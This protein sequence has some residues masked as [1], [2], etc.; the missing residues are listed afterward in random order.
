MKRI[1][2]PKQD[3]PPVTEL[4]RTPSCYYHKLP[5]THFCVKSKHLIYQKNARCHYA[6]NAYPS[7]REN[8]LTINKFQTKESSSLRMRD[9]MHWMRLRK[10]SNKLQ[11]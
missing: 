2:S 6:N 8:I 3:P 10:G 4:G 9:R 1:F 11:Q 5:I 7:I